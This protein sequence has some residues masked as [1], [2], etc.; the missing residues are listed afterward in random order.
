MCEFKTCTRYNLKSHSSKVHNGS[1]ISSF[2]LS[3][4]GEKKKRKLMMKTEGEVKKENVEPA[5]KVCQ[6]QKLSNIAGEKRKKGKNIESFKTDVK[7]IL[8][9]FNVETNKKTTETDDK[10]FI[11]D[12][13]ESGKELSERLGETFSEGGTLA[14]AQPTDNRDEVAA[15][16]GVLMSLDEG[17]GAGGLK[18]KDDNK[19]SLQ[20]ECDFGCGERFSTVEEFFIHITDYHNNF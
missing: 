2:K 1:K 7:N 13:I 15:A 19:L 20:R 14:Q 5:V 12:K 9:P 18:K 10:A 16:V 17:A 4:I 11:R 3:K 6:P 8:Q